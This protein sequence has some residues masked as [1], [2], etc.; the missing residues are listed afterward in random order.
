[1]EQIHNVP[2][3]MGLPSGFNAIYTFGEQGKHLGGALLKM[4]VNGEPITFN[5]YQAHIHRKESIERYL[6]RRPKANEILFCNHLSDYLRQ[7]CHDSNINYADDSG[8]VRVMTGNIC[9]F[10]G[11]RPP[12]KQ[13][14]SHQFMTIGIMKC[15]FALFAEKDLINETYANIASKADIS[16]G[17]V[18][19][20]MKY[21][22]ENNHIVKNKRQRR[23]LDELEL[24]YEWLKNYDRILARYH[25]LTTYPPVDNWEDILLQPGDVWGG[26]VAAAQLTKYNRPHEMLLF[27]RHQPVKYSIGHKELPPLKV[28]KPFWGESLK[29]GKS[30]LALLTMAELLLS[31]DERN[32][33]VAYLINDK[34]VK[35]NQ[36]P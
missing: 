14:K 8:N 29:I 28:V 9:I 22:I 21:L 20:A 23:F 26:E 34:H 7:L 13:D 6:K 3:L 32:R 16:V 35:F 15:L 19:K 27:S 12:I 10:I 36:L 18:T 30:A 25:Q 2:N 11:N 4:T 1:M 17:M 5:I 24:R 33:E 31:K